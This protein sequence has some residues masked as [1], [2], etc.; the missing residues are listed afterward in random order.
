MGC[1]AA[2]VCGAGSRL[3]AQVVRISP[4]A[5]LS[6]PTRISFQDGAIHV[7]QKIGVTFGARMTLTFNHRFDVVT[8]VTYSPGYATLHGAGKRIELASGAHSLGGSTGA[9]YWLL[10]PPRKLS[11]EMHTGVGLVFGGQPSYEDLFESSTLSGVLG[12]TLRYQVG[13]IVTLKLRVDQR[14]YRIS[15]GPDLGSSKR[16]LRVS[17]GLGLPLLESLR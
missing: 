3:Q 9:R 6:L 2:L 10:P 8:A 5:D 14:L 1:T 11:W 15:F 17:F 13:R 16:P 7:R 12:T 4:L